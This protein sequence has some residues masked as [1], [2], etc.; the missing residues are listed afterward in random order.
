MN[1]VVVNV[2]RLVDKNK[3]KMA[4]LAPLILSLGSAIASWAV[5][6]DFNEAEVRTAVGG[7]ILAGTSGIAAYFAKSKEVEVEAD[8]PVRTG[9]PHSL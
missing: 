5:T 3:A 7:A 1:T 8:N 2:V 6:G 4:F 9:R